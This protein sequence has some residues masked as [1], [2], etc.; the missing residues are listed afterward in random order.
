MTSAVTF[1]NV[2]GYFLS[3]LEMN[4]NTYHKKRSE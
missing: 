2:R 4:I 1:E 3:Y